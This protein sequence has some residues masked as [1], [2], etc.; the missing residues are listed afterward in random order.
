[1]RFILPKL[2]YKPDALEPILS[3]KQME[4]HYL[5]HLKGY[6]DKLNQMPEVVSSDKISLEEIIL[7]GKHERSDD[8]IDVL[9]PGSRSSTLY[10]ISSQVY[11]HTFFFKCLKTKGGGEPTGDIA[12]IIS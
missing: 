9:P 5:G 3:K 12:D 11:N 10:N 7:R 1:M 8:R 6:I 4:L 2:P